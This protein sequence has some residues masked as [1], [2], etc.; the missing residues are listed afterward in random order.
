M[1]LRK[2]IRLKIRS[3]IWSFIDPLWRRILVTHYFDNWKI[4]RLKFYLKWRSKK[5]RPVIVFIPKFCKS[6]T[7][8][9]F[10]FWGSG[11]NSTVKISFEL[12]DDGPAF[13]L[14]NLT[15]DDLLLRNGYLLGFLN[16]S[17]LLNDVWI[18]FDFLRYWRLDMEG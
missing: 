7:Y 3:N 17:R 2:K 14:E 4:R 12:F 13:Q 6:K 18:Y 16:I 5:T 10:I 9:S 1:R 8:I 11:C 15:L